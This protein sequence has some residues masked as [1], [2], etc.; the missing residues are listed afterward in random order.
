MVIESET[1][2]VTSSAHVKALALRLKDQLLSTTSNLEEFSATQDEI[3]GLI[4]FAMRGIPRLK[5]RV[6]V[7]PWGLVTAFSLHI[8][9]NPFGNYLNF[10]VG[11]LPS[12]HGLEFIDSSLG[13]LKLSGGTT[14]VL[15]RLLLDLVLSDKQGTMFLNAIESVAMQNQEV[16][17]KFHPIPDLKTR[18]RLSKQRFKEV[19]DGLALL[20]DPAVVR[21]YYERLCK[22]NTLH[23]GTSPESLALYLRPLFE[24]ANDRVLG[25]DD[26][27]REN[28]AALL[29]LGIFLGDGHIEPLV[30]SIRTGKLERC[31]NGPDYVVL[32]NRQDLRLHFVISAVLKVISDSGM[33]HAVGE[34]KE[35]LDAGGGSGFS[36]DDLAADMAGVKLAETLLDNSGEGQR[37]LAALAATAD[38]HIFFPSIEGLPAGLSK[39]QFESDYGNLHDPRYQSMVAEIEHRLALLPLYTK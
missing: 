14:L 8:P 16:L 17:I 39:E 15:S 38:E 11:L 34:F 23:T 21:L 18:L 6:N 7:T 32:A 19:R 20:G 1:L 13:H 37:A 5:G 30:G 9:E 36:F 27:A 28:R 33:S 10:R 35:L 4:Q 3:N 29:A 31:N 12:Q 24:L 26:V 25:A 22:I 2:D